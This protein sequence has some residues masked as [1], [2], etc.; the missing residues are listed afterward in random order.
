VAQILLVEDDAHMAATLR[1]ALQRAGH[2]VVSAGDGGEALAEMK[3]SKVDLVVA[4]ICM[5]NVDGIE[6]I[7]E[8][9]RADRVTKIMAISG[10]IGWAPGGYL[11]A[12]GAVGADHTLKKPFS[13]TVFIDAV[14]T[15]LAAPQRSP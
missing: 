8:I 6:L 7:I 1:N 2:S 14:G 12:A 9:R 11:R 4:D 13:T 5:P 3:R 15:L 10:E